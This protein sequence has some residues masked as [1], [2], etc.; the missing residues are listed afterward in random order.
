M[1]ESFRE[2]MEP[3]GTY[4]LIIIPLIT[5]GQVIGTIGLDVAEPARRFDDEDLNLFNQVSAQIAQAL[6]S[7]RLFQAEQR[8]R[9]AA[10]ALL[11][12]SQLA[13]SSLEL[14]HVLREVTQRSA[15]A[16]AASRCIV[17]L[18]NQ[19]TRELNPLM[20]QYADGRVDE[21][22]WQK[23]RQVGARPLADFP[24]LERMV[25][26]RQPLTLAAPLSAEQLPQDWLDTFRSQSLLAV[27]LFSQD[28]VIGVMLYDHIERGRAFDAA[29]VE[30][31]LTIA[32]QVATTISNATLYEQTVRRAERERL[33]SEITTKVR[34]SNDPRLILQTA[35]DELRAA[36][37][38]RDSGLHLQGGPAEA[39][40][41]KGRG[42]GASGHTIR[43]AARQQPDQEEHKP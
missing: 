16:L 9:Q 17:L 25:R 28:A 33:V 2:V 36:L 3:R 35:I 40:N 39:P 8:G 14:R 23:F 37:N 21:I 15:Q 18:H 26:A 11:E 42:N 10:A 29:Q 5:R 1:T 22:L 32:G 38:A 30:L 27:P 24:A 43:P 20:A 31:S 34:A 19:E 7:T 4:T 13:S 41:G 12:I 6:D